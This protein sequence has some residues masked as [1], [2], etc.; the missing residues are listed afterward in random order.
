VQQL[1]LRN[2]SPDGHAEWGKQIPDDQWAVFQLVLR[3]ARAR[4]ITF[5]AGGALAIATYTGEWRGTK[6]LDFYVVPSEK[7]RMIALLGELG[8]AD[9]YDR[10]PYD[11]RWIYR[12]FIDD[13]IVDVIW[14][15]ANQRSD[16]DAAWLAEGPYLFIRGERV[17][18]LPPEET[19][20][21]KLYVM[22]RDRCDWPDIF[23]VLYAMPAE[24]DWER[25]IRR[26]EGDVSLLEGLLAVFRWL[27]PPRAA[28]IPD[29]VWKRVCSD[30]LRALAATTPEEYRLKLLDT[31]PWMRVKPYGNG[32]TNGNGDQSHAPEEGAGPNANSHPSTPSQPVQKETR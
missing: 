25:L 15:M 10:A 22:Q 21:A 1:V 8:L 31:R 32:E 26:M 2:V 16:V 19:I 30:Q 20:W 17:R 12:S 4:S 29:W 27:S 11:R 9:Y 13:V 24:I 18:I 6:D 5:A 3:E 23:N 28:E 14:S 7:D